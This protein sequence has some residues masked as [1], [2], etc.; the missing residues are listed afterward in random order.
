MAFVALD[1][2]EIDDR[3]LSCHTSCGAEMFIK[4]LPQFIGSGQIQLVFVMKCILNF[5][6]REHSQIYNSAFKTYFP[7]IYGD[8]GLLYQNRGNFIAAVGRKD[9][10][11]LVKKFED[12]FTKQAKPINDEYLT[13]KF[14]YNFAGTSIDDSAVQTFP[15]NDS[16]T[17][18]LK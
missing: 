16:Y 6:Y 11:S 1:F 17:M 9:E 15:P 2:T 10:E 18:Y 13:Y 4:S 8:H 14:V 7:T 5:D 3:G 12:T